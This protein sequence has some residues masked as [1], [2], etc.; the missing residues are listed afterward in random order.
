MSIEHDMARITRWLEES[1]AALPAP[2]PG[3]VLPPVL[4]RLPATQQRRA[5]R[6]SLPEVTGHRWAR[7]MIL[8]ALLVLLAMAMVLFVAGGPPPAPSARPPGLT[9]ELDGDIYVAGSDG[10]DPVRIVAGSE[11]PCGVFGVP[12]PS[13][14]G[15]HIAYRSAWGVDGCQGMITIVDLEGTVIS[16]FPGEGWDISWSP[17]G[18]RVV[19]WLTISVV[20]PVGIYGIDGL[21]Q[22]VL[23]GSKA[24]CGDHDPVWSPDGAESVL[25]RHRDG[26]DQQI[27]LELPVDDSTPRQ[28]PADDPRSESYSPV[29]PP[30]PV[31]YSPDGTH[32]AYISGTDLVVASAD[33]TERRVLVPGNVDRGPGWSPSGDRIAFLDGTRTTLSVVD[34]ATGTVTTLASGTDMRGTDFSPDGDQVLYAQTDSDD[35]SSVWAADTDASGARLLGEGADGGAWLPVMS[36]A[37]T[38]STTFTKVGPFDGDRPLRGA[39]G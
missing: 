39:D 26:S 20:G 23:D 21:R 9:Y 38:S 15:R 24:C 37:A 30:Q 3:R 32:A 16:T 14:D 10:M 28:V 8:V 35:V 25:I 27:V 12:V 22:T 2:D 34:L 7:A 6:L 4:E 13:P 29:D 11:V 1:R 19:T 17:D 31:R 5:S 33:G 18:T 36:D